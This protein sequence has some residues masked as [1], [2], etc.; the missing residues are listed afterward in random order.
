MDIFFTDLD[1]TLIYSYKHDIGVDKRS[2]ERYQDREISY[3]SAKTYERLLDVKRKFMVVPVTTRTVE[4]YQRIELDIGIRYALVCNG[5]IL[6]EDGVEVLEWYQESRRLA[7]GAVKEMQLAMK[8][9]ERDS[10]RTFELRFIRELFVFTKCSEPE[11]VTEE[12]R[13]CLDT[14]AVDVFNNGTKVY[15]L[16]RVLNKGTAVQ[17]FTKYIQVGTMI[18][19]GDSEF[20]IPMLNAADIAIAPETLSK[21][22]RLLPD[23]VYMQEGEVFSE[24]MLAYILAESQKRNEQ[25]MRNN[26]NNA[27]Q[28]W[29]VQEEK[30]DMEQ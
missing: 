5:G 24:Q 17:R 4:Q 25:F 29:K 6:L 30:V 22:G 23:T 7:L 20:D 18:A 19:A 8:Y 3:M 26:E 15:V 27:K 28:M 13:G 2:V 11:K 21:D 1:N 12:L 9:L 14:E 16:P 10:R